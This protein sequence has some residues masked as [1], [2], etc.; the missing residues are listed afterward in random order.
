METQNV[1]AQLFVKNLPKNSEISEDPVE[2]DTQIENAFQKQLD[3][4]EYYKSPNV[5]DAMKKQFQDQT[6]E[7]E[8][9]GTQEQDIPVGTA[10]A[11]GTKESFGNGSWWSTLTPQEQV[12][13]ILACI[14]VLFILAKKFF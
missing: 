1:S 3:L 6:M 13:F 10:E 14:V 4:T 12:L 9:P 11:L 5:F 8:P 7:A 2:S